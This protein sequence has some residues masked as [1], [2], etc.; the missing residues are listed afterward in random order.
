MQLQFYVSCFFQLFL[1]EEEEKVISY[2]VNL[3]YP[4][5]G[6]RCAITAL[7]QRVQL[8]IKM[9]FPLYTL[10]MHKSIICFSNIVTEERV[11]QVPL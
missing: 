7:N 10:T 11:I 9:K 5:I 2:L 3:N 1:G 4:V 6:P 8:S